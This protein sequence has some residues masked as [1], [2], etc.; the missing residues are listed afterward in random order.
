MHR[1]IECVVLDDSM[2][3]LTSLGSSVDYVWN[4]V[5]SGY[6]RFTPAESIFPGIGFESPIA[7]VDLSPAPPLFDRARQLASIAASVV[8]AQLDSI[9]LRA[10]NARVGLIVATSHGEAGAATHFAESIWRGQAESP[11]LPIGVAA[12]V[13]EEDLLAPVYTALGRRLPG[14]IVASACAS[15]A[16]AIGLAYERIVAGSA[17]VY[18]LISVDP[19]ARVAVAGFK[20]F[21][22]LSDS[23]CSPFSPRRDGT[24]VG[25]GAA[26]LILCAKEFAPEGEFPLV[27]SFSHNCAGNHPVEP[28]LEGVTR[29]MS[30]AVQGSGWSPEAFSAVYLHGTGTASNDEAE[31][32][33]ML[34]VFGSASPCATSIKGSIGHTMGSAAMISFVMALRTLRTGLVPPTR[35]DSCEYPHLN[36]VIGEARKI[37][38]GPILV[39][40]VGFGGLNASLTV[41]PYSRP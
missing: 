19:I 22:V 7:V 38:L 39:N 27:T 33:A 12:K 21:G 13:L 17:D 41:S 5:V 14:Q 16:V 40:G 25:E 9:L 32:S 23:G 20:Q 2:A 37:P 31:A 35:S 34:S 29:S 8:R 3:C 11:S 4:N 26:A 15:G 36:L 1:P 24:T 28:S 30:A 6:R 18:V 10:P